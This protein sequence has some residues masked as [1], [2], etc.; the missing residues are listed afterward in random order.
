MLHQEAMMTVNDLREQRFELILLSSK[1]ALIQQRILMNAGA[2]VHRQV[3]LEFAEATEEI[4]G[5]T[6]HVLGYRRVGP[7]LKKQLEAANAAV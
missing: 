4:K 5:I 7:T 2:S 6:L 3:P 1:V